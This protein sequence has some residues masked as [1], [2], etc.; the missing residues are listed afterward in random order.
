MES[1]ILYPLSTLWYAC[2]LI[3]GKKPSVTLSKFHVTS[4]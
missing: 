1:S 4:F 3:D 2:M